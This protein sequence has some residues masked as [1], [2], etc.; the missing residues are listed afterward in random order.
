ME[1]LHRARSEADIHSTLSWLSHDIFDPINDK[2]WDLRQNVEFYLQMNRWI[3]ISK[4]ISVL[5]ELSAIRNSI[6]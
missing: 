1:K 6:K 2:F 3:D 4:T 5:K